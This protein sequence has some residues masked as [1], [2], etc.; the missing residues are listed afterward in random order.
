MYTNKKYLRNLSTILFILELC[1]RFN[2]FC[3]KASFAAT[4]LPLLT[5][6]G[7]RLGQQCGLN[8][9]YCYFLLIVQNNALDTFIIITTLVI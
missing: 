2:L 9:D 4:F 8:A 3:N 7:L 6:L 5:L 1:H